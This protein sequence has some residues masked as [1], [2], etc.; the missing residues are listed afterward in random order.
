MNG[1]RS[2]ATWASTSY[3]TW[4]TIANFRLGRR[5]DCRFLAYDERICA[6]MLNRGRGVACVPYLW[7]VTTASGG[8]GG[9]AAADKS[10]SGIS[11]VLPRGGCRSC[12]QVES[13]TDVQAA[14]HGR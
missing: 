2:A 5:A 12:W 13:G 1:P 10:V 3:S 8:D 14:V 11:A 9:A 7:T 4:L 6:L